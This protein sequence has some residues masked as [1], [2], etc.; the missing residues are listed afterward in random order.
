MGICCE[1]NKIGALMRAT[2]FEIEELVA[3][4]GAWWPG[5]LGRI[6]ERGQEALKAERDE[7]GWAWSALWAWIVADVRRYEAYTQALQAYVQDK[8]LET[9]LIADG[10]GDAD[11]RV[12]TRFKLA[13]RVDPVRWGSR[14]HHTVEVV[15]DLGERLRRAR[16]RVLPDDVSDAVVVVPARD[17]I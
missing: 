16:E 6:A 3:G 4:D 15:G 7:R 14:K 10:S 11:L 13:E 1:E 8:A 9:V 5:F 17:E 12:G 2:T